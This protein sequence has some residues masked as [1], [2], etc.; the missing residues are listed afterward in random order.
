MQYP[1]IATAAIGGPEAVGD[2]MKYCVRPRDRLEGSS[3]LIL[4]SGSGNFRP[5][6][7]NS[8]RIYTNDDD[9]CSLFVGRHN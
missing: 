4:G 8:R 7:E 6:N 1:E 2:T 3:T 9:V 5:W